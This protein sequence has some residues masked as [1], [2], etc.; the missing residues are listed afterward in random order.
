MKLFVLNS[1]PSD[2]NGYIYQALVRALVQEASIEVIAIG[3]GELAQ[4][5]NFPE[6]QCLLI[7]GGEELNK[8][9]GQPWPEKFG[10]RAIWYTEDPY[11]IEINRGTSSGFHCIFTNDSGSVD[12]YED[13]IHLPLAVESSFYEEKRSEN[14]DA[15]IIFFSGTAWP[16]RKEL[17]HWISH[18]W[19]TKGKADFHLVKNEF[20]EEASSTVGEE[21]LTYSSPIAITE[22]VQRARNSLCT[23]VIG[24]DFSGSGQHLYARSP[25]PRLFE[26]GITGS[27]QVVHSSEIPD[28]PADLIEDKH[29]IRFS[30]RE[31]LLE[32]LDEAE[33]AP[34]KFAIIGANMAK[35]IRANHTFKNRADFIIRHIL[36]LGFKPTSTQAPRRL[37]C[38]FVSHEQTRPGFN[39]GGAGL[40]LDKII[41]D[42]PKEAEIQI[43]CRSGDSA[44]QYEI[45][46]RY[47][48]LT[49]RISCKSRVDIANTDHLEL[50]K[51][52][53]RL[54]ETFKPDIVHINHLLG[55]APA[56]IPL[57][58]RIGARVS[59]T[60]HDYFTICDSWNLLNAEN[61][62]C[63]IDQ[64]YFQGCEDCCRK[65]L[66]SSRHTDWLQR[67]VAMSEALAHAHSVIFP[68]QSA[69]D[70]HRTVFPHL[71]ASIVIAPTV[72]SP[73][74]GIDV[75]DETHVSGNSK[76]TVLVPGNLAI[77]KG[78]F[79]L[80]Q[81]IEDIDSLGLSI[82]FRI[83]GRV[84][85]W[86]EEV[87]RTY[88]CIEFMG[89]YSAQDFN[90]KSK[91]SDLALFLSPWPETYCITFDEWKNTGRAALFFQLGALGE[92]H[93]H[94]GL[95]PASRGFMPGQ[96][97]EIIRTL[98]YL[99]SAKGLNAL[100]NKVH[101]EDKSSVSLANH[102]A[103]F[104]RAHWKLFEDL[105]ND[106]KESQIV[107]GYS[108]SYAHGEKSSRAVASVPQSH[109]SRVKHFLAK[110]AYR[111]P[112]SIAT[113]RFLLRLSRRR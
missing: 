99:C 41:A 62:F 67:R 22:F 81:I 93:R 3:P 70:Q 20:V 56:L 8:L 90:E 65:R 47:G 75:N 25:G 82:H 109:R 26:A 42:A 110:A 12:K 44:G 5:R 111:L 87:L 58:R 51:E 52:F 18:K 38:L 107:R 94:E 85:R 23:L 60:L 80:K 43:L 10:R 48:K 78:Y 98:I 84:D 102:D 7:Y 63:G 32:I 1:K 103:S 88:N 106:E 50:E 21:E 91:G 27:C 105:L 101:I 29:Y 83:L 53:Q 28:M 74:Q 92:T 61:T 14:G 17:I 86:I 40:C 112:Y 4:V 79:Y 76:L 100:R 35:Q 39:H 6:E 68:S 9:K 45:R 34:S 66:G 72:Q 46:D 30:T 16:N 2:P 24:R 54:L 36:S 49:G 33:R 59:V 64:F 71:P 97:D 113:A 55:F 108:P 77:N 73:D 104:G 37:R 95:H 89:A 69:L 13:A 15:S 19:D 57:S 11:E 96:I 31:Q